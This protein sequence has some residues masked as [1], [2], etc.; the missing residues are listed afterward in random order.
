[1]ELRIGKGAIIA[2]EMMMMEAPLDPIAGKL[3]SN[4]LT[5]LSRP[6]V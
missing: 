4:L 6:T 3:L 1:V 5:H 2:S